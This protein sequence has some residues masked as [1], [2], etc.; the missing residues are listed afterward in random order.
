VRPEPAASG[1]RRL[2]LGLAALVAAGLL[3]LGAVSAQA[4]GAAPSPAAMRPPVPALVRTASIFK[5]LINPRGIA[6]GPDGWLYVA[7]AGSG[8]PDIPELGSRG[9]RFRTGLT[10]RVSRLD[11]Q[12]RRQVVLDNLPSLI[13]GDDELGATDVAFLDGALYVLTAAGGYEIGNPAWD[14]VVLR[15]DATAAP[16]QAVPI[17]NLT[18]YNLTNPSLSRQQDPVRTDV[19]GGM[20]FGLAALDGALYATDGN[21]EHVTRITPDGRAQRI[22]QY[23]ASN[24]VLTGIAAGPDGA[25]YVAEFGPAPHKDGSARITRLTP[26]G[27]ASAAAEGLVN[28]IDVAFDA[29]GQL[30]VLEFSRPGVRLPQSGRVLRLKASGEREVLAQDLNFP[31]AMA[32]GPDSNLYVAVY[33]NGNRDTREDGEIVRLDLTSAPPTVAGTPLPPVVVGAGVGFLV[34]LLVGGLFVL[35]QRRRA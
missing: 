2:T 23:P 30:Y 18:D 16:S 33:G 9:R 20:P 35:A 25:L 1:R 8:G 21:Q 11:L 13:N 4:P 14:N 10:A 28:A 3:D 12:G 29:A 22:L 7:E 27:Q 19:A 31:T 34:A 32:F 17:F 24:R 6:F 26:D 5:G 15:V